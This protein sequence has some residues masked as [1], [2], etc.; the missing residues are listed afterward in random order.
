ME[1]ESSPTAVVLDTSVLINFLAVDRMDLMGRYSKHFVVT[2]HVQGEI[3]DHYQERYQRFQRALQNNIIEEVRVDRIEELQTFALFSQ[4]GRLGDGECSA[5]AIA[6]H[7]GLTLALD[8]RRARNE[9]LRH[10]P[11]LSVTNTQDLMVSM[12]RDGLLDVADADTIK[13]EWE[14]HHSFRLKISSFAI[15]A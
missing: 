13:E 7:R 12:I 14:Q 3:L 8:D 10:H 1:R 11:D 2:E 9:T 6:V 4:S 15:L 5:I